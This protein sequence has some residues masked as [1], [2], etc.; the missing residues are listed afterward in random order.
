MTPTAGEIYARRDGQLVK[1]TRHAAGVLPAPFK[2]IVGL[3]QSNMEGPATD[4]TSAD[5]YPAGVM[6]WSHTGAAPVQAI[7]P[8]STRRGA[9]G[10]GAG[11][12]FVKDYYAQMPAG[13]RLLYVNTAVGGTGFTLPSTTPGTSDYTWDHT[14]PDNASNLALRTRDLLQTILASLPP[15]SEIVA[16]IA[17]HGSTDGINNTP[18]A[19]FKALLVEW[20]SWL[21]SEMDTPDAPYVMMQMRP[22]LR[23]EPRHANIDDAQREVAEEGYKIGYATSPSGAEYAKSSTDAVHFNAAGLRIIGHSMFDAYEGLIA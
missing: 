6:M 15:G 13:Y 16:Y 19:T 7:E 12:T 17:N 20:I 22:N 2:V 5:A 10:M 11:N 3:M 21:R 8:T 4:F 1:V 23:S 18:K 9:T 14:Q